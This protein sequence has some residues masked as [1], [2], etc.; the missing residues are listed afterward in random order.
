M[1]IVIT[2]AASAI[3]QEVAKIYA[4]RGASFFLIDRNEE[5]LSRV[6]SDLSVRGAAHV[7]AVTADLTEYGQHQGM[8]ERAHEVLGGIDLVLIAH[9]TLP[10]QKKCEKSWEAIYEALA[11][12]QLSAMSFMMAAT[13]VLTQNPHTS[14]LSG[15]NQPILAVI[16]S[17]SGDRGRQSNY[18]YGT[19]KGALDIFASGMRNRLAKTG[20][21][22][23]T[24]KPGFVDTPMTAHFKKGWLWAQPSA[25]ARNIV[26]AIEKKK[27]VVY[28]PWF[29]RYIMLVIR[30]IPE[31]IFK[32]MKL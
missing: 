9:G 27:N 21:H 22:V 16:T 26:R 3:A 18:I 20:R 2:G 1:H 7:E 28:L 15:G 14:P 17:V 31:P 5:L 19:A 23:L 25:V 30:L 12:N 11:H 24:I 29:W 10:D 8:V 6:A 32:R 13:R 4:K